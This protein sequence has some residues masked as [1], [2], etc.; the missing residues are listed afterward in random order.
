L[1]VFIVSAYRATLLRMTTPLNV[2]VHLTDELADELREIARAEHRR[3]RDQAL[4]ML[5]DAIRRAVLERERQ[6]DRLRG[7]IRESAH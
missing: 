2:N 4:V 5:M 7:V 3:V 6:P 1:R